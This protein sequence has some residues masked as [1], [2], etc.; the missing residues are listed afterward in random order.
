M[1]IWKKWIPIAGLPPH[2]LI[3]NIL[4]NTEA[5]FVTLKNPHDKKNIT[6]SF[7]GSLY[8]NRI[9]KKDDFFKKINDLKKKNG[10]SFY[11]DWSM[12]RIENS[13]YLQWLK[14]ESYGVY[15]RDDEYRMNHFIILGSNLVFELLIPGEP[16]F[17]IK[18]SE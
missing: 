16:K 12:F 15:E 13:S 9:T 18:A 14:K 6:M 5:L 2:F 4:S 17:L 11:N 8:S 1:E 7:E 3:D 10:P